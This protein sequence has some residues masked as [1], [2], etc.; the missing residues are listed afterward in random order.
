MWSMPADRRY[1]PFWWNDLCLLAEFNDRRRKSIQDL[2]LFPGGR[3]QLG[4]QRR[5]ALREQD[6]GSIFS[7]WYPQKLMREF[8]G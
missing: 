3:L 5:A 4:L 7:P 6:R 1:R 2:G 8:V